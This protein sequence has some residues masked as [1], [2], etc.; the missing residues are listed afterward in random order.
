MYQVMILDDEKFIRK[1]IRNRINWGAYGLEVSAEASNGEEALCMMDN[2]LANPDI[3]LTDIRMPIMDGLAFIEEAK[4]KFP[5]IR[6]VVMSAYS[7]FSYAQ[8]AI[9]LGV[10]D[11]VLKP[12][13]EEELC[14]TLKKIVYEKNQNEISKKMKKQIDDDVEIPLNCKKIAVCAFWM[15]VDDMEEI[16]GSSL[17]YQ[18]ALTSEEV[19]VYVLK[20][21]SRSGTVV[22]LLN[23]DQITENM[24]LD[25]ITSVSQM[26]TEVLAVS[27]TKVCDAD[28][29]GYQTALCIDILK[30]KMFYKEN[31]KILSE[32]MIWN[33]FTADRRKRA[34]EQLEMIQS[35]LQSGQYE[36]AQNECELII[37]KMVVKDME[38]KVFED[39]LEELLTMLRYYPSDKRENLEDF[40][41]LFSKFR[42]KDYL[43]EYDDEVM[44]KNDIKSMIQCRF[45]PSG[46]IQE[47]ERIEEI[48]KHI[49]TYYMTEL[50]ITEL[51][52]KFYLNPSYLSTLFKRKT[53]INLTSY[54]E[55]VRMEKAKEWMQNKNLSITDIA[56]KTG[57]S[58]S[59]YFSKVFKKYTG[60]TPK[61]Y[62]ENI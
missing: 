12:I 46:E 55:G 34:K 3:V 37:E 45:Q 15:S 9:Q 48:K 50:S 16:V 5:N 32:S 35:F 29:A 26:I 7:D 62:R 23:S 39:V 41:V 51:S 28:Q 49:R 33:K 13:E 58:D 52:Q 31:K 54:I 27:Y 59:G 6:Y 14:K 25:V 19:N 18:M 36:R 17:K 21:Y 20:E 61:K 42:G 1:S 22:V 38:P 57:Y 43:L 4:K 53:G 2:H 44:L 24:I 10:E 60:V 47:K 30:K 11:Y 56:T 40:N 8:K